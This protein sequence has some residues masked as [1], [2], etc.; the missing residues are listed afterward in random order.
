MEQLVQIAYARDLKRLR[1]LGEDAATAVI[2]MFSDIA[3]IDL[4]GGSGV[5]DI[6]STTT[7]LPTHV[8]SAPKRRESSTVNAD[9][10]RRARALAVLEIAR[11][12]QLFVR[13]QWR[14]VRDGKNS[15][16]K[17]TVIT[18]MSIEL[19][20]LSEDSFI[21]EAKHCEPGDDAARAFPDQCGAQH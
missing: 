5:E 16:L 15:L 8:A 11:K 21:I 13:E 14:Q 1:H 2:N 9:R 6:R 3:D 18:N 7:T 20:K 12:M 17:A 10:D 4:D 19:M